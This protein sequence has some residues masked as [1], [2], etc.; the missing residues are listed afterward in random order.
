M[1]S[2]TLSTRDAHEAW[3]I[4]LKKVKRTGVEIGRGAYGRVFEIEYEKTLCAAKEVHQLLLELAEGD[5]YLS[6]IKGNFIH[7][8]HMWGILEHPRIV[9]FI[10]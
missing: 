7:E 6:V 10:G 4:P 3:L 9:Q 8:C 1:H 2:S 5:K